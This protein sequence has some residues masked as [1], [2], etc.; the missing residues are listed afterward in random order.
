MKLSDYQVVAVNRLL[1]AEKPTPTF[2]VFDVQ[3]AGKTATAIN[4]HMI[5]G[6]FPALITV[7]AHLV[8]QWREQL[9]LWGVNAEDITTTPRGMNRIKR[10]E[11]LENEDRPWT[12]VSY[13]MWANTNYWPYLLQRKWQAYSFDESHRLRKGA[14]GKKGWWE[15][16]NWLRTK[17]KSTH[18]NTPLWLF[19]GTPI[20]SDATDVFPLLHLA[21]PS[22]YRSREDFALQYCKTYRTPYSLQI[23]PVRDKER[24]HELLGKYSLR[25]TWRDIPELAGLKRRDIDVPVELSHAELSRHRAIKRDYRDPLTD[26]PLDS[27]AAMIHAL[28][29]LTIEPK[30]DSWIELIADHPGRWLGFTWYRD[31]A[32]LAYGRACKV[33]GADRVGYVDG[34]SSERQ[35]TQ[36]VNRYKSGGCLVGTIGAISEGLNLQQG[37]QVAFLERHWL[38]TANEQALTRVFR[39]GQSQPVLIFW[40]D[41]PKTFDMRV[42][43]VSDGRARNIETALGDFLEDEEWT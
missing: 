24:F 39:R 43:K 14:F 31:S 29:R 42:K 15:T 18:L 20:V 25:R 40:F 5:S 8:L 28:R 4:A 2:G 22:V 11:R 33:F 13:H 30:I 37:H 41:A 9:M 10:V 6:N 26:T 38:S 23:G 27:S 35:R 36:A 3:G 16:V 17:T 34:S 12:I 1:A 19:S 21:A 7:P 32:R